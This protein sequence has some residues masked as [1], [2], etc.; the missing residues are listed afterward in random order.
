MA[1][2]MRSSGSSLPLRSFPRALPGPPPP[3]PPPPPPPSSSSSSG[4]PPGGPEPFRFPSAPPLG[5]LGVLSSWSRLSEALSLSWSRS[6]SL[7]W[8]R[9]L[10]LAGALSWLSALPDLSFLAL[11]SMVSLT[12]LERARSAG[13]GI[14]SSEELLARRPRPE[15][16]RFLPLRRSS[17]LSSESSLSPPPPFLAL[18]LARGGLV[19]DLYFDCCFMEDF[20]SFQLTPFRDFLVSGVFGGRRHLDLSGAGSGLPKRFS[21]PDSAPLS[22]GSFP[23][24]CSRSGSSRF[25]RL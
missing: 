18:V 22:P 2:L 8:S 15:D 9:P 10:S 7:P 4:G 14:S 12:N 1:S 24:G 6:L 3:R 21:F 17:S 20:M 16:F 11:R 25:W 5:S 19:G 13:S 23:S